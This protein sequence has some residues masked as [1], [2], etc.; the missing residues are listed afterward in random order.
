MMSYDV[1]IERCGL[2]ALFDL[3]GASDAVSK[4]VEGKIPPLPDSPNSKSSDGDMDVY[5][6]GRDHWILRASVEHEQ[7]LADSLKPESCPADI[8]IVRISDTLT[9]FRVTGPDV[10][11]VMSI[12]CSIDLHPSMFGADMVTNTECFG[13]KAM[14]QRFEDG[15]E[16]AVEQSY[17]NYIADCLKRATD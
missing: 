4:W 12:I 13:Q 15:F 6:I 5:S 8:S 1:E 2:N 9:F 17:G 16:F 3:K 14:L 11:E 7:D 10:T